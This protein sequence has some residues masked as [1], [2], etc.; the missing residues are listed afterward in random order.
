MSRVIDFLFPMHML[1]I[2]EILS[3]LFSYLEHAS[4]FKRTF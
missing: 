4:N 3:A 1:L 2:F